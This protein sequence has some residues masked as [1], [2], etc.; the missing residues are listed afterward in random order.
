V[1]R[2][3]FVAALT[4]AVLAPIV[5]L[6][7][8]VAPLAVIVRGGEGPPT[9][10]LLHGY[11]SN[12]E[13]W[14]QFEGK[15]LMP[16]D[17]RVIYPQGPLRSPGG[18]RGWWWLDLPGHVPPG[19]RLPDYSAANPGG[20]KVASRLVGNLL[21]DIEGPIVLG[22]FSQGA[23]L[24]AEIAFQT[25][26]ALAGLILLGGTTVNEAA[27][28]ERVPGRRRL[29]IFIGHGRWDGV[30]PF[31][32]MDRFQQRLRAAGLDVT[33]FPFEGGHDLP[34]ELIGA[35]NAFLAGLDLAPPG[36]P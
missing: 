28:L 25:D 12:A 29:P 22:G 17:G 14:L 2:V 32:A 11:G 27:W 4:L 16:E 7:L 13:D 30:L 23:M 21:D 19:A 36:R 5:W 33:W 6:R 26:Q 34:D 18:S 24:S 35:V 20:L 15:I 8:Q 3:I 10:V 1:K 9:L 31:A